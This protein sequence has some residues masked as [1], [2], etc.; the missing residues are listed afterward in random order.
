LSHLDQLADRGLQNEAPDSRNA[1]LLC[2]QR[3]VLAPD[4]VADPIEKPL[5]RLPRR[6][7][8]DCAAR[9]NAHLSVS[10]TS[11]GCG[12]MGP[13]FIIRRPCVVR[14]TS[15]IRWPCTTG[16]SRA[17][18]RP[19]VVRWT[20]IMRW[21]CTIGWSRAVRRPSVVRWTRMIQWPCGIGWSRAVRR[22]WVVRRPCVL[23]RYV[24]TAWAG[25]VG[26]AYQ[27]QL[28]PDAAPA[29]QFGLERQQFLVIETGLLARLKGMHVEG[30]HDLPEAIATVTE[31]AHHLF[32]GHII[33][34]CQALTDRMGGNAVAAARPVLLLRLLVILNP[35]DLRQESFV[36]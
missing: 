20:S 30:M 7:P 18:L 4:P 9:G 23:R 14:W 6:R 19:S 8:R 17:V 15:M 12:A 3:G 11:L 26:R 5:R 24:I 13:A 28:Q 21:P 1:R 10:A 16:W 29:S 32:I 27:P 36:G 34:L 33:G 35:E 25:I 22:P 31:P 2:T